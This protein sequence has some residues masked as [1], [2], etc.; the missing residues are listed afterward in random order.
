[1]MLSCKERCAASTGEN[2]FKAR[3][4]ELACLRIPW[5]SCVCFAA[6]NASVMTGK[7]K[8]VAV[9]IV[10]QIPVVTY[11]VSTVLFAI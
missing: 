2:I 7:S 8:G 6:D 4:N 11:S 10:K 3:D 5:K 1:M 9:L